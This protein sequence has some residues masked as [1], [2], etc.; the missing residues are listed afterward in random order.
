MAEIRLRLT[1]NEL[2]DNGRSGSVAWLIMG[3]NIEN[4]QYVL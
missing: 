1:E 4:A 3:I 2:S